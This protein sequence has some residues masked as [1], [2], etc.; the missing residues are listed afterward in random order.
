MSNAFLSLTTETETICGYGAVFCNQTITTYKCLFV[1]IYVGKRVQLWGSRTHCPPT[2]SAEPRKLV[3]E[4]HNSKFH[5]FWYANLEGG[6]FSRANPMQTNAVPRV[7]RSQSARGLRHCMGFERRLVYA[8]RMRS[9][10]RLGRIAL[11]ERLLPRT[12]ISPEPCRVP[13]SCTS[14]K[15]A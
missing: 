4:A 9:V 3:P 12:L 1:I 2:L 15:T 11:C 13:R 10:R 14:A 6:A 8:H 7:T 5:L